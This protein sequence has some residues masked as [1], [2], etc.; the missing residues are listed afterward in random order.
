[1]RRSVHWRGRRRAPAPAAPGRAGPG[2]PGGAWHV[3]W[4]G[5]GSG[6][7]ADGGVCDDRHLRARLAV[8]MS[9]ATLGRGIALMKPAA[10]CL[11]AGLAMV[12]AAAAAQDGP[13]TFEACAAI[14]TD[15]A[16]LACYDAVA[17]REAPDPAQADAAAD[18]AR[19][20]LQA[21]APEETNATRRERARQNI[22][23]LFA[24]DSSDPRADALANAGQGSLLDSRWELAADSK[25]G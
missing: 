25:L 8:A 6:A 4:R 2:R 16:R 9:A 21:D 3:D 22:R 14:S 18:I 19:L 1:V 11:A 23:G 15:A 12:P 10:A 17:G 7:E 20:S 13:A 5:A 24:F